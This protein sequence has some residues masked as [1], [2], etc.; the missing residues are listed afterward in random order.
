MS[1]IT[2]MVRVGD[3]TVDR[4]KRTVYGTVMPYGEVALVKDPGAP[5]YKERFEPGSLARTLNQ[6]G[7]KIRLYG[8]H[9]RATGGLPIGK[10]VEWDDT[11]TA[12]RGAFQ[13]FD[14]TGGNDALELADPNVG[15][16]AGFSIGF[17]VVEG[18]TKRIGD[19]VSR[20]EATLGEV[21]LVDIP[22]Y[23]GATIDGIRM[24]LDDYSPDDI[25][26]WLASL[27][28]ATRAA[29]IE[30]ARSLAPEDAPT[31]DEAPPA[32]RYGNTTRTDVRLRVAG[33]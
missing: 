11:A 8:M 19:I 9:S 4:D 21:S 26:A 29:F 16:L 18:G 33:F 25:E 17:G 28:P 5:P 2:R 7:D 15:G 22:A 3:L 31:P 12:L 30:H 23:A 27:T 20:T 14:T 10:P 13:V 32:P 6:R 1:D 24:A